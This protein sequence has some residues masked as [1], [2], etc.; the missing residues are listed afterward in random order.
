MSILA[1]SIIVII[2]ICIGIVLVGLCQWVAQQRFEATRAK[3]NKA[4]AEE[5]ESIKTAL[6]RLF[7]P[8]PTPTPLPTDFAHL[9]AWEILM[10]I[11]EERIKIGRSLEVALSWRTKDNPPKLKALVTALDKEDLTAETVE[12][13]QA[14]IAY[15]QYC[16]RQCDQILENERRAAEHA[17]WVVD[18]KARAAWPELSVGKDTAAKDA[19]WSGWTKA[20][21]ENPNHPY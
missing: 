21:M 17:A 8:V 4:E 16:Q 6:V 2:S 10:L 13:E 14:A 9:S 3:R 5:A 20:R 11:R 12:E 19:E 7:G 1:I 18:Q 15:Q